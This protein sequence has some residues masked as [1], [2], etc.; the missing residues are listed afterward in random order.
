MGN[1]NISL[2]TA[3]GDMLLISYLFYIFIFSLFDIKKPVKF[4]T[5]GGNIDQKMFLAP[6]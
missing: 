2:F 1:P 3:S 4:L 5:C 6:Q